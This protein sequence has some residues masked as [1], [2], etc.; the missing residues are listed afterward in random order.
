MQLRT[1]RF[2]P[3]YAS[4]H[5]CGET[6]PFARRIGVACPLD[7]GDILEKRSKKGRVFYGCANWP[8]CDWVSWYR[9]VP[10][11]CPTCGGLQVEMGRGRLRCLK[12]EGEP[13]RFG[14][15]ENGERGNGR[16]RKAK[17]TT[18]KTRKAQ[19]G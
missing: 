16:V 11:P 14:S 19:R 1:G 5:E 15:R 9:P 17:T 12:H 4:T 2:G 6:K 7:G 8:D 10:D 3:F 18:A 13:A